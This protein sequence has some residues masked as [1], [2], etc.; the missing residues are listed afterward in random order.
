MDAMVNL[1]MPG[2]RRD[3]E[4]FFTEQQQRVRQAVLRGG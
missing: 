2:F 1:A 3:L 4:A